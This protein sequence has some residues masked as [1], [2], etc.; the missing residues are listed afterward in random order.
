M[1]LIFDADDTLWGV[2]ELY[3][4][5]RGKFVSLMKAQGLG[6]GPIVEQL[7]KD[8][9]KQKYAVLG[10]S[11][12]RFPQSLEE[13]YLGRCKELNRPLYD[14]IARQARQIGEEVFK[15]PAIE[16]PAV[17]PMLSKLSEHHKLYLWTQGDRDV[18]ERRLKE[19]H[20]AELFD[21]RVVVT[22]EKTASALRRQIKDWNLNPDET[23]MIGNSVES[24]INPA[25]AIGL[26]AVWI[27]HATWKED[28]VL[29][30][31]PKD[32]VYLLGQFADLDQIFDAQASGSPEEEDVY[33]F[34]SAYHSLFRQYVLDILC[35][36]RDDVIRFPYELKLV[37]GPYKEP[38]GL[39]QFRK[40]LVGKKAMIVFTDERVK[41]DPLR[42]P[43]FLPIRAA[44]IQSA[45]L[46]GELIHIEFKLSDYVKLADDAKGAA[47]QAVREEDSREANRQWIDDYDTF[48]K[49]NLRYRPRLDP[50]DRSYVALGPRYS[51]SIK[52]V[53]KGEDEDAAWQRLAHVIGDLRNYSNFNPRKKNPNLPEIPNPFQY[54]MSY[55]VS[56]LEDRESGQVV[57]LKAPPEPSVE[58][59]GH[60]AN[61]WKL[62]LQ[63]IP[64]FARWYSRAAPSHN[65]DFELDSNRTFRLRL[66]FS[67]PKRPESEVQHS[68]VAI[69]FGPEG[70]LV[71]LDA[72]EIPLNFSYDSRAIDF[73][74]PRTFEEKRASIALAIVPP[75]VTSAD[76]PKQPM[77]PAP[78][79]QIRIKANNILLGLAATIFLIGGVASTFRDPLAKVIASLVP[80]L[81][82]SA[83]SLSLSLGIAGAII[84]TAVLV[85]LY[86]TPT[87]K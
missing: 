33:L 80:A 41:G 13:T 70:V 40:R 66:L 4:T 29:P 60:Q 78:T 82:E 69:K 12:L 61:G 62:R 3:D 30:T 11:R 50:N 72:T 67:V 74:V 28:V 54:A 47:G 59:P 2:E 24:D 27:P 52:T 87:P 17:Q 57:T 1:N 7:A 46:F 65:V 26:H 84:T 86:R 25:I 64:L 75:A 48:I 20:L 21:G 45:T 58:A 38:P 49:T 51:P 23:W 77:T 10:T 36:P 19:C 63:R 68:K 9:D 16:Y 15:L 35:N 85:Y 43:N 32:V 83:D 71:P 31:F 5:Q 6:P 34:V 76:D 22:E 56:A 14:S 18:Q 39:E 81:K 55:R 42:S 8:I 44:I 53:L 73:S 37:P 79:F